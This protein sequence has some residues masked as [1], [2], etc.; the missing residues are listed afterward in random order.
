MT[1]ALDRLLNMD[2]LRRRARS[3]LPKPVF[4]Y[5]D[6]AA[7]NE[8]TKGI[9]AADFREVR[10]LPRALV[11]ITERT[12]GVTV[13]GEKLDLPLILAPTGLTGL[14]GPGGEK[15]VGRAARAAGAVFCV[16][17]VA[18]QTVEEVSSAAP[19]TWF[20]LYVQRDRELTRELIERA[21]KAGCPVLVV[22]VDTP[23]QGRRDRD[24]R[25]GFAF[26]PKMTPANIWHFG[27]HP[28]FLLR[29]ATSP[30]LGFANFA[31]VP[32]YNMGFSAATRQANADFVRTITWDDIA[33][34][35]SLFPGKIALKGILHPDDVKRAIDIGVDGII[36]SNHGGRQLEGATS[37]FRALP[38]L[39]EAA[40]DRIEVIL[41]GGVRSGG[42]VLKAMALGAKA[43][44]VGRPYL[45]GLA[46]G[47]EA[48]VARMLA[49]LKGEIQTAQ[50]QLGCPSLE[51]L[52]ASFLEP[53]ERGWP[54][55][56]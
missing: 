39:V 28:G 9:N 10:F 47:G 32:G 16:S 7:E 48:G 43:C 30:K 13:L 14:F 23:V 3:R 21:G 40:A 35:K 11:D 18:T 49:I 37:P 33:W 38:R 26:P 55:N 12:Q 31:H 34:F 22:T 36:A 41:D 19:G 8:W 15:A 2:D 50:A 20:Q 24:I 53:V 6:G 25:N 4:D 51:A 5:I 46:A 17:T 45:Y 56:R 42:D 52:D 54:A 27:T 1:S 44:M 29:L